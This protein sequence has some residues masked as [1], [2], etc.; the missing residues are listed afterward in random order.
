MGKGGLNNWAWSEANDQIP[1]KK[2]ITDFMGS[3]L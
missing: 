1:I 2:H 3:K